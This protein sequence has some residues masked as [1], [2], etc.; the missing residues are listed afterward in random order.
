MNKVPGNFHISSHSYHNYLSIL[1]KDNNLKTLDLSHII[2][3]LSFGDI[4]DIINI[5]KTFK[6]GIL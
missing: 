1:L 6:Q 3:H 5:Q 2:N 4:A